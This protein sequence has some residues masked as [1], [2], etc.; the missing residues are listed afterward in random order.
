MRPFSRLHLGL[1][2]LALA[3]AAPAVE[4]EQSWHVLAIAILCAVASCALSRREGGTVVPGWAIYSGVGAAS[5]YLLYEMFWPH[6]EPTVY[7]LDLAHFMVFLCCC[8][9]FEL[10]THRDGSLI[11]VVSF[12]LVVISGF[13]SASPVF[14]VVLIVDLTIGVAW[15]MAFQADRVQHRLALRRASIE[16]PAAASKS[17]SSPVATTTRPARAAPEPAPMTAGFLRAGT[18]HGAALALTAALIFV[19]LP[20]GWGRGLF[21]RIH[22][23]I[24]ASVTGFAEEIELHDTAVLEDPTPVMRVRFS[25]DDPAFHDEQFEPYM[26]G[27]TYERY[28]HGRWH[29]VRKAPRRLRLRERDKTYILSD[30]VS[31]TPQRH[32]IK[33]EV[34]LDRRESGVLFSLYP[35]LTFASQDIGQ[36]QVDKIDYSI[37]ADD[38]S[39]TTV[40][41]VIHAGALMTPEMVEHL[42]P[43]PSGGTPPSAMS[44]PDPRV[45]EFA[46]SFFSARGDP[47]DPRQWGR[48]AQSLCNH[49][50]SGDYEYTL[51][52]GSRSP[53]GDPIADFLFENHRGHCEFFA[54]AMVLMCQAVDIPARIV[55]GFLGGEYNAV[56][57]F[58]QFRQKDA[59]AWVEVFLPDR[60]WTTFDPSPSQRERRRA[61]DAGFWAR[62]RRLV[63]FL[64]FQWSAAVLSFD[65][66]TRASFL[67]ALTDF[68]R[69]LTQAPEEADSLQD[70]LVTVLWGPEPLNGWQRAGYW[71]LLLLLIALVVLILRALGIVSVLLK[72]RVSIGVRPRTAPIRVAEARFY[73]RLLLLLAR[74]GHAKPMHVT[75][76][77]FAHDL[78]REHRDL[79][80]IVELTDWF[81]A[82]QFGGTTPARDQA[83]RIRSFLRRLREDPGFGAT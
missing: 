6:E 67:A 24:P 64:Q 81:Y 57:G 27:L 34:W 19:V 73:D 26:R 80:E 28:Q 53:D 79:E 59:H 10:R 42:D 49:L 78:A 62:T 65:A 2:V 75:P 44:E 8:K 15:L 16:P 20:R 29:P 46:E 52:R 21:I 66:D 82:A 30:A 47:S 40:R 35:P 48:L 68:F 31:Y 55:N 54:S 61:D 17:S 14:A 37:R 74:K 63:D 77:E 13:A 45:R 12:L 22:G 25:T 33:Q 76:R 18:L 71:L 9:F 58:H 5:I 60:G 50:S 36:V 3:N 83:R 70:T 38:A 41:Y 32:V 72:E 23:V 56:G 39:L 7:I 1:L 51:T 4:V 11:A 69:R 43:P